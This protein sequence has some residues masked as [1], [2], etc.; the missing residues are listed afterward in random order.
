MSKKILLANILLFICFQIHAQINIQGNVSF[1]PPEYHIKHLDTSFHTIYYKY[2]FKK[3]PKDNTNISTGIT[4][5]QIG[6]KFS[7]FTDVYRLKVDSL[8][9]RHSRLKQI[10]TKEMNEIL[11]YYSKIKF[12]K[13]IFKDFKN[14]KILYQSDLPRSNYEYQ[15]SIPAFQWEIKEDTKNILGYPVQKAK[16][17]YGGREWIAWFTPD[18]PISQGPYIFGGLPGLIME[19]HDNKNN[20][21]FIAVAMDNE[22]KMIYKRNYKNTIQTTKEKFAKVERSFYEHPELFFDMQGVKG[23]EKLIKIPYNPIELENK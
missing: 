23:I 8:Q 15:I 20:F 17:K 7:K 14:K 12:K 10:G 19:M 22:S 16:M 11:P 5:L 6:K 2:E 1:P 13:T 9:K 3:K 4:E 21:R 18:I